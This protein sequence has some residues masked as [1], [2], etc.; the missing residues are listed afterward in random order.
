MAS[1]FVRFAAAL[2]PNGAVPPGTF[3]AIASLAATAFFGS[4]TKLRMRA[5]HA[6]TA[7]II[8]GSLQPQSL[9]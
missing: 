9:P 1:C 2:A 6:L 3:A 8:V 7:L 4:F 5:I